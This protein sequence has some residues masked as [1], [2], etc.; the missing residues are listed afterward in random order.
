MLLHVN[1][2]N[3]HMLA[4]LWS[5][6]PSEVNTFVSFYN[7]TFMLSETLWF[8][9]SCWKKKRWSLPDQQDNPL[10]FTLRLAGELNLDGNICVCFIDGFGF[11]SDSTIPPRARYHFVFYCHKAIIDVFEV[12]A[13]FELYV[14][15][16]LLRDIGFAV[17]WKWSPPSSS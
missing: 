7:L 8:Y 16:T 10:S 13:C 15:C 11:F 1:S 5:G 3:V 12:L 2:M 4:E 14:V 6:R 9:V 17:P